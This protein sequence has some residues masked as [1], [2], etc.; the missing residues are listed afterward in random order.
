M[1]KLPKRKNTFFRSVNYDSTKL[2][3]LANKTKTK[4]TFQKKLFESVNFD[5]FG[6]DDIEK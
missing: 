6:T 2:L 3:C 5:I 1:G 4:E